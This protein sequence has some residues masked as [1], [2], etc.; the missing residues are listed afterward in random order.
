MEKPVK[1]R[2][3]FD[4][5]PAHRDGHVAKKGLHAAE[6]VRPEIQRERERFVRRRVICGAARLLIIDE[7]GINPSMT[8]TYARAVGE[9]VRCGSEELG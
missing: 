7:T 6:V 9:R 3:H 5:S 8:R 4:G 1:I 2:K